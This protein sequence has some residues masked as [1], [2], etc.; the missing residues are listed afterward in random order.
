[1][2]I[3]SSWHF[4]DLWL[5]EEQSIQSC[6]TMEQ[7]LW[8]PGMNYSEHSKRWNMIRSKAFYRKMEQIGFYGT[9]TH[10]VLLI[11]EGSG[12][13]KFDLQELFWKD[14]WRPTVTPWMLNPSEVELIINSRPLTVE[15]ISDSKKEVSLS[16]SN[17]LTIKTIVVMSPSGEFS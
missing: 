4:L 2:L 7:I 9:T 17:H 6:W 1:M 3:P 15:T 10:L 16:P 12:N 13:A 11:W 14:C 5:E 8:V